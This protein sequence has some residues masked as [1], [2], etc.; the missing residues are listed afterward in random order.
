MIKKRLLF[1]SKKDSCFDKKKT[2]KKKTLPA[3][4]VFW[5]I[6]VVVCIDWHDTLDQALNAIGELS[7]RLV[8]KF[9]ALTRIAGN[10]IEFHIVSYAGASKVDATKASAEHVIGQLIYQGLPFKELHLARHPCGREGKASIC[11]ALQAHCLVD[12][13][14][15]ILNENKQLGIKTF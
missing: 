3:G 4:R 1:L 11:S 6:R 13:R 14:S 9:R 2:L 5:K 8:E 7:S 12:D 15:D 10:R